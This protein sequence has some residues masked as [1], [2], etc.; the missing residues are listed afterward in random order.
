MSA[1]A[2]KHLQDV[3]REKERDRLQSDVERRAREL[4][5]IESCMIGDHGTPATLQ[6]YEYDQW[7]LAELAR[8]N[9]SLSGR[10]VVASRLPYSAYEAAHLLRYPPHHD[11]R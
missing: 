5:D 2:R 7:E 6:G 4:A 8:I 3:R 9:R 1:A 10:H 11:H